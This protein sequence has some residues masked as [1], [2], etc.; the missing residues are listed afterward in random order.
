MCHPIAYYLQLLT[1]TLS[2]WGYLTIPSLKK[3]RGLC[4]A[5]AVWAIVHPAHL[6]P[7]TPQTSK[8]VKFSMW[9]GM[10]AG[11]T[12]QQ[13]AR[14]IKSADRTVHGPMVLLKDLKVK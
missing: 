3:A 7:L 8:T 1:A 12:G 2:R 4:F 6:V 13:G 11:K 9:F 14:I 5:V 10:H